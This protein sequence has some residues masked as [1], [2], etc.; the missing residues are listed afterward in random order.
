MLK[1][2][3]GTQVGFFVANLKEFAAVKALI[4][5]GITGI[6]MLNRKRHNA[7][8]YNELVATIAVLLLVFFIIAFVYCSV[9]YFKTLLA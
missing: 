6:V 1:S 8:E 5:A 3:S 4:S 7:N 9:V 2:G